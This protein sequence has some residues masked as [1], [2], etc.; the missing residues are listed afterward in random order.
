[1]K[2]YPIFCK[3]K[4]F[5]LYQISIIAWINQVDK[6]TKW[7]NIDGLLSLYDVALGILFVER[8]WDVRDNRDSEK[9]IF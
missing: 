4:F 5:T 2:F 3:F 9:A 7:M 1:M 6:M 8:V